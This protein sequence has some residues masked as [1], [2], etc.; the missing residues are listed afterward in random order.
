ME[1]REL[2]ALIGQVKAG[3]AWL[4]TQAPSPGLPSD[5]S[6]WTPRLWG[7]DEERTRDVPCHVTSSCARTATSHSN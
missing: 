6:A 2:R 3:T 5:F 4:A 7:K 1:E